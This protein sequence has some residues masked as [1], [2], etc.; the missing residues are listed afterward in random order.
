MSAQKNHKKSQYTSRSKVIPLAST[1]HLSSIYFTLVFLSGFLLGAIRQGFIIP[2]FHLARS[3]AELIE[4]PFMVLCTLH[5]AR[6]LIHRYEVPRVA[7]TRIT[8]GGLAMGM[9]VVIELIGE[10]FDN[11]RWD[12][13]GD[14]GYWI[15][16]GAF[17]VAVVLFGAMLWVLMAV[18][19]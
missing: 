18:G 9:M 16:K 4:M 8:V 11:G 13:E 17:S 12:T 3:R 15:R 6:W 7:K 2:T 1:L 10:Y 5:W 14:K 19:R